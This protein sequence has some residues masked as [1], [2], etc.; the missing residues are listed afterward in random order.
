MQIYKGE[1]QLTLMQIYKG[2]AQLTI[3]LWSFWQ[4][5]WKLST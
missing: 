4:R 1:A 2:E 3:T 5:H